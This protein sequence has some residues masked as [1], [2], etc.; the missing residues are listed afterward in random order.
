MVRG[1]QPL[2]VMRDAWFRC[3]APRTWLLRSFHLSRS[4]LVADDATQF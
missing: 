3:C 4:I 1:I 2:S